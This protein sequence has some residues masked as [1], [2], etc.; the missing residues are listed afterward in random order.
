MWV[1]SFSTG[2][3]DTPSSGYAAS[4]FTPA[5]SSMVADQS[6]VM[7]CCA[8]TRPAGTTAGQCAIQGTRMP[9][10]VR[11]ILPPT[12][13]QLSEKRSPPLSLARITSVLSAMPCFWSAAMIQPMPSSM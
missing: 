1:A 10:S 2:I 6:M 13:G 4:A 11:S 8:L 7:A 5:A 9:P 12:S 3:S